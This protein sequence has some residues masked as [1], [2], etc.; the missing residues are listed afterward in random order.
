MAM[1]LTTA[2]VF[3]VA[4]DVALLALLAFVMGIPSKLTP[5]RAAEPGRTRDWRILAFQRSP[6]PRRQSTVYHTAT[7]TRTPSGRT[8][9]RIDPVRK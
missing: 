9:D 7:R 6:L 8:S 3:F 5:H 4:L 2:I 1:S